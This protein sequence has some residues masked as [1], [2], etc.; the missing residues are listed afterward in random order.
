MGGGGSKEDDGEA[1]GAE[2]SDQAA[3]AAS[4]NSCSTPEDSRRGRTSL[5]SPLDDK[6]EPLVNGEEDG[7]G[8]TGEKKGMWKQLS[9]GYDQLV[10]AVIRPPR[11][12]YSIRYS[13][14][15]TRL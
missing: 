12:I 8:E 4:S 6:A 10:D 9:E 7:A 15:G 3:D 14:T 1:S 5:Q 2:E 11:S 13:H